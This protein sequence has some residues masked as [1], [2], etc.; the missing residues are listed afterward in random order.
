MGPGQLAR[1]QQD[2]WAW[3][4]RIAFDSEAF[5]DRD[6]WTHLALDKDL[7]LRVAARIPVAAEG[8]RITGAGH[9]RLEAALR[10]AT[11]NEV[12]LTLAARFGLKGGMLEWEETP[13]PAGHNNS[14]FASYQACITG[15][16]DG[17]AMLAGVWFMLP[18]SYADA[19]SCVIDLRLDF[20]AIWPSAPTVPPGLAR[21]PLTCG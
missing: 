15:P 18:G 3:Q 2:Q 5:R 9:A 12:L 6:A 11:F 7:R 8:L 14:R 19:L 10:Q 17:V 20:D 1:E 4:P 16:K 13:E 21:I